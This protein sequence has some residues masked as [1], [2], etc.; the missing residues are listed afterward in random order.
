MALDKDF[1]QIWVTRDDVTHENFSLT[2]AVPGLF[3]P[4]RVALCSES[5]T[6]TWILCPQG[7]VLLLPQTQILSRLSLTA[8]PS[9]ES[10][11]H[12]STDCSFPLPS[13]THTKEVHTLRTLLCGLS[14][15]CSPVPHSHGY[16]LSSSKSIQAPLK[17]L[18]T[19]SCHF[20]PLPTFYMAHITL[21]CTSVDTDHSPSLPIRMQIL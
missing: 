1:L 15:Q 21:W 5:L 2:S 10:P 13:F 7:L 20:Y 12:H 6:L 16:I 17:P 19:L 4:S 8:C 9:M 3:S 18:S 14:S 11:L